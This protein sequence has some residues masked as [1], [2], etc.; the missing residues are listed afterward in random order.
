[1]AKADTKQQPILVTE[2]PGVNAGDSITIDPSIEKS[3]LRKLDFKYVTASFSKH[4]RQ[5]K[6][7]DTFQA[8][9]G[10]LVHVFLQLP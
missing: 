6:I 4:I 10:R 7:I 8:T 5:M 9:T 2:E 1:M 3:I